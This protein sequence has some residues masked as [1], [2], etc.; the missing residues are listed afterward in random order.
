MRR[1]ILAA[2][3]FAFMAVGV[4]TALAIPAALEVTAWAPP[5]PRFVALVSVAFAAVACL[6]AVPVCFAAACQSGRS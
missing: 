1:F 5:L 3:G 2:L 6:V 4:C